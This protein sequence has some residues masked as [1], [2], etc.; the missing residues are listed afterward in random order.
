A[1]GRIDLVDGEAQGLCPVS[2]DVNVDLGN[3]RIEGRVS[4]SQFRGLVQFTDEGASNLGNLLGRLSTKRLQAQ[5]Q[6]TD[7]A[8]TRD[9]RWDESH[10]GRARHGQKVTPQV[11]KQ[12]FHLQFR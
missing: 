4:R 5:I 7:G 3:V 6:P 2:I 11:G 1:Q 10:D 12:T 9:G 8:H